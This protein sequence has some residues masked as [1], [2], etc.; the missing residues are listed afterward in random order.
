M[1]QFQIIQQRFEEKGVYGR[2]LLILALPAPFLLSFL[3]SMQPPW[4]ALALFSFWMQKNGFLTMFI[5]ETSLRH[6]SHPLI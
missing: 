3:I 5:S 1:I 2:T 6:N 4:W